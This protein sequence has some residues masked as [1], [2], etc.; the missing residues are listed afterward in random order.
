MPQAAGKLQHYR[1]A[2]PI[3]DLFPSTRKSPG[4]WGRRVDLKSGGYPI[5]DQTEALTTVD[6]NT[7]GYVGAR[8]FDDTIFKTNLRLGRHRAPAA[9]AQPGR[10]H[11]RRLHRH[12]PRRPTRRPCSP[13]SAN[14][15]RATASKPCRGLFNRAWVE[16]TRKRT[17]ES[18]AHMPKEPPPSPGAA[19]GALHAAWPY[20]I[21]REILR[22]ARQFNPREFRQWWPHRRW[23]SLIRVRPSC[24]CELLQEPVGAIRK[25]GLVARINC[26]AAIIS[27]Q[28]RP[29]SRPDHVLRRGPSQRPAPR[30]VHQRQ[31]A[32]PASLIFHQPCLHP[33][34]ATTVPPLRQITGVKEEQIEYG[35]IGKLQGPSSTNTAPTSATALHLSATPARSSG[36]EL[37][38]PDRR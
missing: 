31:G 26:G 35:F 21:L 17:R 33:T 10:H 16:M 28:Q 19:A 23:W 29:L 11:H 20:D 7:G 15:S 38:P 25:I 8:N 3:F 6:V 24:C 5:I 27:E 9:P 36:P 4:H 12:G 22:E 34:S 32:I 37:C 30:I 18:L 13:N 1:R 14:N 2:P